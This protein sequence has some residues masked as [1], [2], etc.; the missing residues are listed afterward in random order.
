MSM[1]LSEAGRLGAERTK[2]VWLERYRSNP[3]CC[4]FCNKD[5]PYSQ[6]KNIFCG[7]SCSAQYN[8]VLRGEKRSCANCDKQLRSKQKVYCT[9]RCQQNHQWRTRKAVIEK[10]GIAHYGKVTAKRYI[11]ELQGQF[12][13]VCGINEWLEQGMNGVTGRL[14]K[15]ATQVDITD[16]VRRDQYGS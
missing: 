3:K 14:R 8:N 11:E 13:A 10:T 9:H 12:C 7:H 2:L 5:L 4:K 16:T 1:S 6:R 15:Q